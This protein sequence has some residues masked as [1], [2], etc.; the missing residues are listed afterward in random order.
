M[1]PDGKLSD[2]MKGYEIIV[3]AN[4]NRVREGLRVLEEVARFLLHDGDLWLR[5]RE[6]R[7]TLKKET[8]SRKV[9]NDPGAFPFSEEEG[10]RRLPDLVNANASRVQEGLRA[11]EEFSERSAFYKDFR[12]KVYQLHQ[13]LLLK[14]RRVTKEDQLQGMYLIFD[15]DQCPLDPEEAARIAVESGITLFQLRKKRGSALQIFKIAKAIKESLDSRALLIVND[16]LDIALACGDGVHLGM[17]D[18]PLQEARKLA[19]VDFVVGASCHT[20]QEAQEAERG[21]ASYLS[22]GCLFPTMSKKDTRPVSLETLQKVKRAVGL[23]VCAIGGIT[24]ENIARVAREGPEMIAVMSSVW[25]SPDPL[26]TI[27]LLLSS[28]GL[29]AGP[30]EWLFNGETRLKIL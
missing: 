8:F 12:F 5:F 20:L 17:E 11:L 21:G 22:I 4:E 24:Q 1:V 19:P 29:M 18:L 30:Q 27:K 23:P 7:H 9:R 14:V 15:P 25:R 10:R 28:A 26:T 3:D 2:D 13:E 16:H 6:L